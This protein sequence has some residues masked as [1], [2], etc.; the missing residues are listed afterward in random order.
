MLEVK[1]KF[2]KPDLLRLWFMTT[3]RRGKARL[4]KIKIYC[5]TDEVVR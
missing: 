3:K 2:R 4:A 5:S 1:L